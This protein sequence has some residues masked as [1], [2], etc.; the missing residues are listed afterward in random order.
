MGSSHSTVTA[1]Q[2]ILKQRDLELPTRVLQ[3]FV[4]EVECAAPWFA[5]SGSLSPASWKK[6][7]RDLGRAQTV[8]DLVPGTMAI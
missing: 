2:P 4:K 6:L 1:L 5:V 8:G 7:D 3:R